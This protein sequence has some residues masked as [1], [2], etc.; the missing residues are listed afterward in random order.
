MS[1]QTVVIPAA[2]P[3]RKRIRCV[4]L[5]LANIELLK[6]E[7]RKR[8]PSEPWV[9]EQIKSVTRIDEHGRQIVHRF[10]DKNAFPPGGAKTKMIVCPACDIFTP[11]HA[12]EG[13]QCLDHAEHTGWGQSPSARAIERAEYYHSKLLTVELEPESEEALL[14][15]IGRVR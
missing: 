2:M 13:G 11:P 15:E 14:E 12:F 7:L 1:A 5:S 6:G 9:E 10:H 8:T 4:G 3:T